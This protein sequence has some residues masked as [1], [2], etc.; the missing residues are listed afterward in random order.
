MLLKNIH[1]QMITIKFIYTHNN[2]SDEYYLLLKTKIELY[3]FKNELI[4]R[5][6]KNLLNLIL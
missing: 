3:Y 2:L 4:E 1:D 5:F 6:N